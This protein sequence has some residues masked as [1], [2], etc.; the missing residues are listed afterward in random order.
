MRWKNGKSKVSLEDHILFN[1]EAQCYDFSP[2]EAIKEIRSYKKIITNDPLDKVS[3]DHYKTHSLWWAIGYYNN[4]VNPFGSDVER[5]LY[6]PD[7]KQLDHK[8]KNLRKK[9]ETAVG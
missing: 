4:V 2:L 9:L 3:F 8:L 6:I 7:L 5:I 1:K